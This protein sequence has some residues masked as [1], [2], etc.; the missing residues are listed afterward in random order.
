MHVGSVLRL[1]GPGAGLRRRSSS[2]STRGL[3]LVPRY[4]QR[5]AFPPFGVVAAGL[6]R[7]PALQRRLPRAPHRAARARGRGGAARGSPGA[8]SRSNSTARSRCGRSGSSTTMADDRFALICKTHHALVDGISGVDI[9]TVLF[10]L[11]PDP[12]ERRARAG[13]GRRGR[14]RAAPSCSPRRSPSAPRRRSASLRGVLA[15]PDRAG[16]EAGRVRRRAG[17]DGRGGRRGRAAEPAER[18]DRAAPALRVGRRPTWRTFKAIKD[19]L[20]GTINDVVL[21][22]VTGAL[23]AH[24]FR[25]GRDPEG[26]SSRRWCRSRC[27]PTPSAAR[28][29]TRSRRCTRRCR[30]GSTDPVERF[31]FVHAAMAGLKESGQAVG[32]QAITR[33]ADA[34]AP[35]VLDQAARLQS[36]QRFFNLTVT[37]V[38]GPAGPAVHDGPQARGLLP[39]GAARAQHRARDRDHVLRRAALL[40]A[41]GRL[42]R[43]GRHR[44]AGRRSRRARSAS[45]RRP[46]ACPRPE[47]PRG[48]RTPVRT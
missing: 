46:P 18:A 48:A 13:R 20:G 4:R 35:T 34:A 25:H 31:R 12:P 10:D 30:S 3:H 6:G 37:N 1:R 7:R 22:V 39:D 28:S 24:L 40:R 16:A 14:C 11:D 33:L 17:G 2:A 29:A 15:H 26:S 19:A 44:R 27:A 42:R 8:C 9:L 45:W 32:A 47:A 21:T 43:A 38:P 36:R 5:L 23:R 41:A